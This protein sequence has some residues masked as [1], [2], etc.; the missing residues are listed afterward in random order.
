M[1]AKGRKEKKAGV[2]GGRAEKG[3]SGEGRDECE[4]WGH[5]PGLL[6]IVS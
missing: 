3:K 6:T 2:G 1:E 4:E 5:M